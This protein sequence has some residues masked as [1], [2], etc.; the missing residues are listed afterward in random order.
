MLSKY[1]SFKYHERQ[2]H[3]ID[4]KTIKHLSL[5]LLRLEGAYP[6]V[7]RVLKGGSGH[8]N[9]ILW[10]QRLLDRDG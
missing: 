1:Y 6:L 4:D 7:S 2:R 8:E 9:N 10:I 3:I 5:N